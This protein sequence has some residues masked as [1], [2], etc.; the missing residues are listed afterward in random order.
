MSHG[1]SQRTVQALKKAKPNSLGA[2]L[3]RLCVELDLPVAVVA[4]VLGVSRMT[5]YNWF[6]GSTE[7]SPRYAK[8]IE[9]W[10]QS[11]KKLPNKK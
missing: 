5:V 3:G 7:P 9:N 6:D 2:A 8:K 1:Y 10:L 11:C 4:E